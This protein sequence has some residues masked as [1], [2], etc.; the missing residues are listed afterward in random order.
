M[1]NLFPVISRSSLT[2]T[3]FIT[4][5]SP[6]AIFC[7]EAAMAYSF[8]EAKSQGAVPYLC[9]LLILSLQAYSSDP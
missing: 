6:A 3:G 8:T 7:V 4:T 1:P 2:L 9:L 5:F